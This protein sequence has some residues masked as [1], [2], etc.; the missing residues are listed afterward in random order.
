MEKVLHPSLVKC[1]SSL[2]IRSPHLHRKLWMEQKKAIRAT[3]LIKALGK[4]TLTSAQA[5]R[6]DALGIKF[7]DE[8]VSGEHHHGSFPY[9]LVGEAESARAFPLDVRS[10]DCVFHSCRLLLLPGRTLRQKSHQIAIDLIDVVVRVL[11]YRLKM[12]KQLNLCITEILV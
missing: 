5:K 8:S 10:A 6:V 11:F 4:P 3:T 9:S 12:V 2:S 7:E 1:L